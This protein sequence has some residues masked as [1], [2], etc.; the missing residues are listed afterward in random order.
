MKW[1]FYLVICTNSDTSFADAVCQSP[2]IQGLLPC[3]KIFDQETSRRIKD[4]Q[5]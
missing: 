3:E 1:S 4:P 2:D 5:E